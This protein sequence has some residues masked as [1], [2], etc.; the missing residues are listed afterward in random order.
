MK[1][2]LVSTYDVEGGAARAAY[3][4]HQGLRQIGQDALMLSKHKTSSDTAIRKISDSSVGRVDR[5]DQL[6]AIQDEYI[7]ANRTNLSN[8]IFSLP[9]PGFD[10]SQIACVREADIIN[11]HWIAYFQSPI[12]LKKLISLGKPIVWTL[13]DM[14]AFTGGCHYSSGCV[15]YEDDCVSCPQLLDDPFNIAASVLK[16]KIE[17]LAGANLTIVAPSQWL[18][19]CARRSQLFKQHPI[20]IIPYGLETDVFTPQPKL[21][22]KQ[23]LGIDASKTTLLFGAT[24][25]TELRK[26]FAE[27]VES[28]Q[29]CLE[30]L[31]FRRLVEE[32]LIE[33]ICFGYPSQLL[34]LLT[35]PVR[36]LGIVTSDCELR[37][38]YSAADCFILPS[39]E[40]N[41]PNTMMEAMSCGTPVIAFDSGGI[42][43]MVKDGVTGRLVLH[44]DTR[45]LAYAILDCVFDLSTY[46]QMG[47]ACRQVIEDK[48]TIS[49]QAKQ[50]LTLF[51]K[52]L[53]SCAETGV[54]LMPNV[55][56]N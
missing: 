21:Y 28:M 19:T 15:K 49:V 14:W 16:D 22:A 12:T 53:N 7:N 55:S 40:D 48:Y 41:L 4:L 5:L 11:L 43:D 10:L 18:A 30:D 36:S 29:Y 38:I 52:L 23:Q 20:H 2:V 42:P 47:I 44:K 25:A 39:L 37:T 8:T 45:K 9:Y 3:R 24:A 13:H 34:E 35:I 50:Y 33:I 31:K 27:L 1:V 46:Q 54:P 26:G 56:T 17:C 51:Q 32:G 6:Q